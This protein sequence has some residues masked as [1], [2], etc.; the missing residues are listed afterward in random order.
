MVALRVLEMCL[1]PSKTRKNLKFLRCLHVFEQ[2]RNY[3]SDINESNWLQSLFYILVW[4]GIIAP[5]NGLSF[6][7]CVLGVTLKFSRIA[8]SGKCLQLES[9]TVLTM[10]GFFSEIFCW[11]MPHFVDFMSAWTKICM[12]CSIF[13]SFLTISNFFDSLRVFW[14]VF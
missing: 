12:K 11:N 8:V 10:I 9:K 13:F 4:M 2:M 1:S 3:Y 5:V 14:S 6:F 7:I